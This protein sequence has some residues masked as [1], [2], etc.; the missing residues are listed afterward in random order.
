M[1]IIRIDFDNEKVSEKEIKNLSEG[2]QKIVSEITE[3]SDVFVY[4]NSSQIKINIAPV[5]IFIEM[6]T[7]KINNVDEL[8]ETIKSDLHQ[9][10]EKTEFPYPLNLTLVP[11]NWKIE[12]NI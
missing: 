5:E 1:P 7:E 12:I 4:A 10:K 9:W 3:I 6:S 11:M 2:I 8:A